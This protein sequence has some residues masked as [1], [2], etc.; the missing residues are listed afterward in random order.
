MRLLLLILVSIVNPVSVGYI[1]LKQTNNEMSYCKL[2]L[3]D[4]KV[5][6]QNDGIT[7]AESVTNIG[8][9]YDGDNKVEV[10][11]TFN[12]DESYI[13]AYAKTPYI[14]DHEQRHFDITYLY[15]MKFVKELAKLKW[16][17]EGII[18]NVYNRILAEKEQ[19]QIQYDSETRNS[20]NKEQQGL[21]DKK[22]DNLLK[23][24]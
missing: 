12:R 18:E 17:N 10:F 14:L 7:A 11:C 6:F 24:L 8:Y 4:F 16:V 23:E 2:K 19:F 22:I 20:E 3:T 9:K 5:R 21:W 15:S 1:S 13:I